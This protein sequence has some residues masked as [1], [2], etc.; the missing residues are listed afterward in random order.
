MAKV[1]EKIKPG[2]R[3]LRPDGHERKLL[4]KDSPKDLISMAMQIA[5]S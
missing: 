2:S 1:K 4:V 5:K 3:G